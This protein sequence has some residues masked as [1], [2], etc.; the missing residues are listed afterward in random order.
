MEIKEI[1]Q[2]ACQAL[3][4]KKGLDIRVIDVQGVSAI[5]EYFIVASGSNV[6]QLQALE[7]S[8]GHKMHELNVELKNVEGNRAS[9]WILM[10]YGDF[11]VHL[12]SEEDRMFYDLER[13]WKDGK[14]VSADEL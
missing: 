3:E 14:I 12:F 5:A 6:S 1:V 9:T 7:D 8:V 2:A 11:I 13:I 10:D 4:D